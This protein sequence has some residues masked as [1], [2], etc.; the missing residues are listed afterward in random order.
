MAVQK[1]PAQIQRGE[2]VQTQREEEHE[3]HLEQ[4]S[5]EEEGHLRAS[6]V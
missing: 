2:P 5:Q 4:I 6:W 1:V 3:E